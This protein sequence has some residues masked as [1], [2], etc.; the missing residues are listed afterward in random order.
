MLRRSMPWSSELNGG[1]QFVAFGC[2]FYAFEAQMKRMIGMEDG[3]ID[4]LFEFSQPQ[5]GAYYWCPP[6][7]AGRLNLDALYSQLKTN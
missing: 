1:L 5:N 6:A 2:S 7:R 3:V 4:G